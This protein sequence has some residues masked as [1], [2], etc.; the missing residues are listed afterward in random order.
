MLNKVK[1]YFLSGLMA[2]LPVVLTIYLLMIIVNFADGLL[3]KYLQPYFYD[4]FGFYFRGFSIIIA[5]Y[6]VIL[7]G[8]L[9]TNFIGKRIYDFFE[10]IFIKLPF[11][12][13]IYPAVKEMAMFLF[14]RDRA[15]SF[16][17]VVIVEYPRKGIYSYG[18]LTN[19][20]S[21]YVNE[22]TK[23]E[24]CNIF[25][26]SAPGPL[27]GFAMMIPTKD[28][29]KTDI[30]VEHAFKFILSGGVVNPIVGRV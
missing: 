17:Q 16:Q 6:I 21:N 29:I 18:F 7:I 26:P 24:M 20:T 23:Q 13:Q 11:V 28:I 30:A 8:F 2:L 27:T 14:V 9:V 4:Q 10:R 25:I 22:L 12:K 19:E 3:G 1:K 5:A 15:S